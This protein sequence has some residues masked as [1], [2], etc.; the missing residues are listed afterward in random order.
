MDNTNPSLGA[1]SASEVLPGDAAFLSTWSSLSDDVREVFRLLATHTSDLLVLLD[2]ENRIVWISPSVEF[3]LHRKPEDLAGLS[4]TELLA[5]GEFDRSVWWRE[6]TEEA[7]HV[8]YLL[9]GEGE[10]VPTHTYSL[11]ISAASVLAGY[12]AVVHSVSRDSSTLEG[13][14]HY[15]QFFHALI[16][17]VNPFV[18]I[19]DANGRVEWCSPHLAVTLH[20]STDRV[21]GRPLRDIAPE[22]PETYSTPEY[23]IRILGG[24]GHTRQFRCREAVA[25]GHGGV[26]TSRM[27]VLL[28]LQAGQEVARTDQHLDHFE[29]FT[30]NVFLHVTTNHL[31]ERVSESV[32]RLLGW[33]VEALTGRE[34][35][36]LVVPDS[37][38]PVVSWLSLSEFGAEVPPLDLAVQR[39]DGTSQWV[40][41]SAHRDTTTPNLTVVTLSDATR[42]VTTQQAWRTVV[43]AQR[44][45]AECENE[46]DLLRAYCQVAVD[47]GGYAFSWFGRKVLDAEQSVELAACSHR[48]DHYLDDF[49]VTWSERP[50]GKGPFGR[51]IVTGE[52]QIRQNLDADP[53]YEPWKSRVARFGFRSSLSIPVRVEGE[54]YGVW[55]IYSADLAAFEGS[56]LQSLLVAGD[57]LGRAIERFRS[58]TERRQLRQE[59]QMLSN[60]MAQASEMVI[61]TNIEGRMTYVNDAVL[62]TTGYERDE[63]VGQ[64][65]RL[66]QSGYQT[67]EFYLNLWQTLTRGHTWR[68]NFVNRKKSG[69]HYEVSATLS[70]T[71]DD[72]GNLTGYLGLSHEVTLVKQLEHLV[73]MGRLDHSSLAA[74]MRDVRQESSLDLTARAMCHAVLKIRGITEAWFLLFDDGDSVLPVGTSRV[75]MDLDLFNTPEMMNHSHEIRRRAGDGPWWR[76][77]EATPHVL[78]PQVNAEILER[79]VVAFIHL[80]VRWQDD[81]VGVLVLGT[82]KADAATWLDA[83]LDAF[84]EVGAFAG[85]I[86]GEQ[87]ARFRSVHQQRAVL[88][89]ILAVEA[90]TPVFQ[91]F[92]NLLTGAVVGYEALTRFHDGKRPDHR[93]EEAFVAG[94][95][96]ELEAACARAALLDAA[97]LPTSTWISLNFAPETIISGLARQVVL[98]AERPIVIEVTEHSVIEN[99]EALRAALRDI[100]NVK[101]AVDDAGSGYTSLHHIVQLRPDYVKLDITLIRDIDHDPIRQAMVAGLCYFAGATGCAIIAE[102]IERIEEADVLRN[103]GVTLGQSNLLGQGYLFGRPAPLHHSDGWR[104]PALMLN[105]GDES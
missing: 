87:A 3:L 90:W 57:D 46:D 49:D 14:N 95:G 48:H 62:R 89:E 97:E 17:A 76:L 51:A 59:Q 93:F 94:R 53:F 102:G 52:A 45:I 79:G 72:E 39:A 99:Y 71:Y 82:D 15:E 32:E 20:C 63:I 11:D 27:L 28:S 16:E 85:S 54:V 30:T 21:V 100:P 22:S 88:D 83:R 77:V 78:D 65:P 1:S 37:L 41:A 75:E 25:R 18:L 67:R 12:R 40:S 8:V 7:A 80:P 105:S 70:P 58:T 73:D 92:T 2:A 36:I 55:A 69:E 33:K 50:S 91:P 96:P 19:V 35:G 29:R 66:L 44:A 6:V 23:L 43:A 104:T 38:N 86:L 68:G 61:I 56:T 98:E 42:M 84:A 9:S 74:V 4:Y 101:V 10:H 34:L 103:L 24:E 64:F 26:V 5:P 47:D 13:L 31:I 81:V 60:A